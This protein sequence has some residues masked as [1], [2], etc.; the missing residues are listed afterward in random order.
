MQDLALRACKEGSEREVCGPMILSRWE[1]RLEPQG[2]VVR[3]IEAEYFSIDQDER[4]AV[5]R[6]RAGKVEKVRLHPGVTI[7]KQN[8]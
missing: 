8:S 6:S 5:F 1:V 3:L 4:S 2:D 7:T